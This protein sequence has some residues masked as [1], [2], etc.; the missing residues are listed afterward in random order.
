MNVCLQV[1][2]DGGGD[3]EQ[4]DNNIIMLMITPVARLLC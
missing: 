2:D 3:V 4:V 1:D